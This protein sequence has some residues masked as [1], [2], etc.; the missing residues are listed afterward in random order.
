MSSN[1]PPTLR[2]RLGG[3]L[4]RNQRFWTLGG[5]GDV[6]AEPV[7]LTISA[8]STYRHRG[9]QPKAPRAPSIQY[10]AARRYAGRVVARSQRYLRCGTRN[11]ATLLTYFTSVWRGAGGAGGAGAEAAITTESRALSS[12]TPRPSP[13]ARGV[14]VADAAPVC[15]RSKVGGGARSQRALGPARR[16]AAPMG[17]SPQSTRCIF[18]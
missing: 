13:T 9:P 11:H 18:T 16:A 7:H 3:Q 2:Q 6:T 4:P 14:D 5:C 8:N 1:V 17:V 15:H 12:R 10:A